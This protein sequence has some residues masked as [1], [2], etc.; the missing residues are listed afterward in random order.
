M[1][2][3]LF[4]G[5]VIIGIASG[6]I[7]GLHSNTVIAVLSSFGLTDDTMSIL[8]V[9]LFA[10]HL[11]ASF[12]PSIFF[13]IPSDS[14][15]VSV[16]PGQRMVRN[17]EGIIALKVVIA[18]VLFSVLLSVAVFPFSM[19]VFTVVYGAIKPY[20]GHILVVFSV[21]FLLKTKNRFLSLCV[22]LLAGILGTFTLGAGMYDAFLPLFSGFF[23]MA[24]MLTYEKGMKIPPQKDGVPDLSFLKYAALGVL[25]GFFADLLPGIGSPSQIATFATIAMPINTIGYL[26]TISSIAASESIFSLSTSA[27]IGK[28]RMGAT[29]W[30]S[31]YI[32][33]GDNLVF[34]L[35]LFLLSTA[36][37]A[38]AIY[39]L[40]KYAGSLAALDFSKL[41]VLL[42][43]YLVAVIYL[44][45]G[46]MGL[47]V[48]ALSSALGYAALKLNVERTTLMGA[49]IVPTILLLFHLVTP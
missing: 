1:D 48:F 24:A 16:L 20:V 30:L 31:Q 32:T 3:L 45:D 29:E 25:L 6:L 14:S 23:A 41:N 39:L 26:A 27:S 7:P 9:S 37:A 28:S 40:R 17:G 21:I 43:I 22:F 13:G 46:A 44:L 5:G 42:A 19:P 8:I 47:G 36:L 4:L 38:L 35:V 33:I 34:L 11:I 15:I 12:I 18:S 10:A 2:W 49:I